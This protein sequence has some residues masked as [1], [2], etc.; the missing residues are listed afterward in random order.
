M[1]PSIRTGQALIAPR[2]TATAHLAAEAQIKVDHL[3]R[4]VNHLALVCEGLWNL[5]KEKHGYTDQ[6]L[7]AKVSAVDLTDGRLD[8]H[9]ARIAPR[10][11]PKCHRVAL[12]YQPTCLYCGEVL[13]PAL[14][15]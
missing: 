13:P 12:R 11:C 3:E 5:L 1:L 4:E 2:D 15:E 14:F 7:V 9:K 10:Q 6:D 8:D